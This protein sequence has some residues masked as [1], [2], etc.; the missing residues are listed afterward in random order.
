MQRRHLLHLLFFALTILTNVAARTRPVDRPQ[1]WVRQLAEDPH[2]WSQP[3][4]VVVRHAS[5]DLTV[6]FTSRKLRGSVRL[7][8]DNITGTTQLDLDT[9]GLTIERITLDGN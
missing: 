6:D 4:Q 5:L 9:R 2:S 7:D 1:P 3:E 8:I